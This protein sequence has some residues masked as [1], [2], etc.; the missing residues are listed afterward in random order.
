MAG[1]GRLEMVDGSGRLSGFW[2]MLRKESGNWRST[3]RWLVQSAV[4]L[5]LLNGI[6]ALT[7]YFNSGVQVGGPAPPGSEP[8]S[9]VG[10]F[11][12][13]MGTMAPLGVVILTQ[14][15]IVGE[16]QSGTAEWVLSAPL[17]REAFIVSKLVANFG[18]MLAI[19]VFLQGLAFEGI[20]MAFG[21][22]AVPIVNLLSGLGIQGLHL[23]FWITLSLML[24]ALFNGRGPVLGISIVLLVFQDIIGELGKIY[25][26]WIPLLLPK[27][28]PELATLAAMGNALYSGIPITVTSLWSLV[29]ILVA[30]WRFKREEF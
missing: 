23:L 9:H 12:I 14:S 27:R 8:L 13:L 20:L 5:L 21:R 4:W 25:V 2:N 19:L 28:L 6:V 18:W 29:F 3:R 7:L 17:S 15:D 16:K 24:G 30:I 10:L 26:P 1:D 11:F 22:Q